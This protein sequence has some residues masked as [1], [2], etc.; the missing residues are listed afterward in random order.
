MELRHLRYFVAVA[1]ELHF[2]RA[3]QRLHVSTPTLSQQIQALEREIG[4]RLFERNSRGVVL[5]ASGKILL[6]EA[7]SVLQAA[8]TALREARRVGGVEDPAVRLGL[9]HGAP[10]W[11]VRRLESVV[12]TMLPGWRTVLVGGTSTD[13]I[14]LLRHGDVDLAMVRLPLTDQNSLTVLPIAREELGILMSGEHPLAGRQVL[15]P[16][17]LIGQELVW[18]HRRY[19]TG[20]YD[21]TVEQLRRLVP[22][23]RISETSVSQAQ[24]GSV[25]LRRTTPISLSS[26]RAARSPDLVW[27]PIQDHPLSVT[28]GVIWASPTP[29]N[30]IRMLTIALEREM[31]NGMLAEGE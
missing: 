25:L 21:A 28:F 29:N 12:R 19:A 27:R 9:L 18:I 3:A 26:R 7:R 20:F 5:T 13:Q 1:E 14:E 24:V 16:S 11:L 17:E 22:E 6:G 2:G 4:T 8:E 31:R 23:L 10:D 15:E 30:T